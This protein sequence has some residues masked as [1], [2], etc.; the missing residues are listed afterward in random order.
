MPD[1]VPAFISEST[2]S[3]F[4]RL[5]KSSKINLKPPLNKTAVVFLLASNAD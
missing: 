4:N 5:V 1:R 3:F 2:T